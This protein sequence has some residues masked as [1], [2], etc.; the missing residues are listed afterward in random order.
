MPASVCL[1]IVT[2]VDISFLKHFSAKPVGLVDA[3]SEDTLKT[4]RPQ[5]DR[6]TQDEDGDRQRVLAK[7]WRFLDINGE[8]S[9]MLNL[10]LHLHD[11]Q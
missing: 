10:L 6:Y 4:I 1:P 3:T 7:N 8:T 2:L 11:V 9:N 5:I